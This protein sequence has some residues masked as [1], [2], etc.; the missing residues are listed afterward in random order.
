MRALRSSGP[1]DG[2]HMVSI[3]HVIPASA[4]GH[5]S[6]PHSGLS[7]GVWP[8][9]TMSNSVRSTRYGAGTSSGTIK[10]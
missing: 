1:L 8:S 10:P 2:S 9:H 4:N 3:H 6:A 7:P 5:T